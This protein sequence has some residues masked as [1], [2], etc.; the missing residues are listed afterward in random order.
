MTTPQEYPKWIQAPDGWTH[1]NK[2][3]REFFRDRHGKMSVVVLDARDER[4]L[5][6]KEDD[7]K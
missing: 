5:F 4:E 3:P 1:H 6:G 7:G 2:P